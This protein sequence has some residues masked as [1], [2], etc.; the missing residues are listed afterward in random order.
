MRPWCEQGERLG[1]DSAFLVSLCPRARPSAPLFFRFC[2]CSVGIRISLHR[3]VG[4]IRF[5]FVSKAL[6]WSY[7]IIKPV[8][9]KTVN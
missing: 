9:G 2:T 1:P 4:R 8:T 3:N 7:I 6:T 5:G